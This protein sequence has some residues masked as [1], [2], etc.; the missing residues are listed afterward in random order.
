LSIIAEK[1]VPLHQT[2]KTNAMENIAIPNDLSFEK[3]WMG[4]QEV[5]EMFREMSRETDRQFKATDRKI[6]DLSGLFTTQWGKLMEAL[7]EPSCLK[8][9]K[10][11]KIDV[12]ESYTN[13]KSN[14]DGEE[15]EHDIVLA[16]GKEVVVISVKT[17]MTIN[18]VNEFIEDIQRFKFFFPRWKNETIYGA[19]AGIKY[20]E[21]S[22]KYAYRQGFFVLKN[23]GEG[24][25]KI[26]NNQKFTPK[27]F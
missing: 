23:A 7:I 3:V 8:L 20:V 4:F 10:D 24:I 17:T 26:A 16:N 27:A 1:D 22:D 15:A 19:V 25:I 5:K 9:F 11:R 21:Q 12:S 14:K 6:K 18:Y 2:I 13:L